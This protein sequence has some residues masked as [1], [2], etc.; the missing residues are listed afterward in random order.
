LQMF[1]F[2][3]VSAGTPPAATFLRR[4]VEA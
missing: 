2:R 4:A 1:L 3:K